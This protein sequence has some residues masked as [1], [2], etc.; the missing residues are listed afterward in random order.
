LGELVEKVSDLTPEVLA[1]SFRSL[2]KQLFEFGKGVLDRI[3][4]GGVG[5]QEQKLGSA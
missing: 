2:A 1:G 3:E 5:W 4:I